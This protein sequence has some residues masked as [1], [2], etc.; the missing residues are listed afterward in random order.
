[1]KIKQIRWEAAKY[2][3]TNGY[4]GE[5]RVASFGPNT[6]R[7]AP[8]LVLEFHLG[9]FTGR[10]WELPANG[11]DAAKAKAEDLLAEYVR[12]FVED[13]EAR[14]EYATQ[15]PGSPPTPFERIPERW[16]LDEW[17]KVIEHYGG[18]LLTRTVIV[19]DWTPVE[20]S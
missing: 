13:E 20:E 14:T 12:S 3:F 9:G 1:M 18:K 10:Y 11:V 16:T 8:N 17:R 6:K 15:Y 4:I 7:H 2:G 19:T 5:T